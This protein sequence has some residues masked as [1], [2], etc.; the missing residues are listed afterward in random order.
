MPGRMIGDNIVIMQE[1][2]HKMRHV[3]GKRAWMAIRLYLEKAYDR[4]KG[5]GDVYP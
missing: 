1:I 3:K 5:N 2:L 4:L